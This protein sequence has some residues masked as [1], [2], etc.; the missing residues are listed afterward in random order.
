MAWGALAAGVYN[1]ADGRELSE[2][3][4]FGRASHPNDPPYDLVAG[5]EGIDRVAPLVAR[6]VQVGVA[7][8]AVEDVN[9]DFRRA[10]L[11]AG[12]VEGRER[13]VSVGRTVAFA[14]GHEKNPFRR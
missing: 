9:G 13:G 6:H 12:K 10:G 8:A 5:N 2:L 4:L 3:E 14:G 7:D 11:A 1:D